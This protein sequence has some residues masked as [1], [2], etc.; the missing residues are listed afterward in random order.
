MNLEKHQ[1]AVAAKWLIT[2]LISTLER[3]DGNEESIG[4]L[5][6]ILKRIEH[7]IAGAKKEI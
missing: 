2:E 6:L 3:L 1:K 4:D 7:Q 5:K